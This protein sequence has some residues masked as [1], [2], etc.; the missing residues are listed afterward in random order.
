MR[1]VKATDTIVNNIIEKTGSK[2]MIVNG[3]SRSKKYFLGKNNAG[4]TLY[5][6]KYNAN[7][8]SFTFVDEARIA[9]TGYVNGV[10]TGSGIYVYTSSK[11]K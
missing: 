8:N 9:S 2:A 10:T 3:I 5:C 7:S 11:L 4:Y 1:Y 6:Y